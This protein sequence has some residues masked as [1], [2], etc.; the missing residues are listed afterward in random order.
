MPRLVPCD[1]C[2]K[3]IAENAASCPKCGT[4]EPTIKWQEQ[5]QRRERRRDL[6]FRSLL[7]FAFV[8]V[9]V[10]ISL[11]AITTPSNSESDVQRV[12]TPSYPPED[13][14][15]VDSFELEEDGY[16]ARV[17][18]V[19]HNAGP[20]EMSY[21]SLEFSVLDGSGRVWETVF[22]ITGD[23]APGQVWRFRVGF[24]VLPSEAQVQLVD[25][26]VLTD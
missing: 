9:V 13:S 10:S 25:K 19:A 21:A 16:F 2:R 7:T 15:I 6:T 26:L 8:A 22:A 18:G 20:V 5:E 23:L 24:F 4:A 3:L 11:W 1:K 14:L 12:D 17:V